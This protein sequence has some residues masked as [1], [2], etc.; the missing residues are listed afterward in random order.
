MLINIACWIR[1][2][3]LRSI[4]FN[5][6][7][8][9]ALAL[10]VF[11]QAAS[12]AAVFG[13]FT[14]EDR[15]LLLSRD[16]ASQL[17]IHTRVVAVDVNG[18]P[19]FRVLSFPQPEQDTREIIR[20]AKQRGYEKTWYF[21][22]ASARSPVAD[23]APAKSSYR[24][25][26]TLTDGLA[27]ATKTQ[28]TAMDSESTSPPIQL[29]IGGQS[30]DVLR[31]DA[32]QINIDGHINEDVWE[33][34]APFDRLTVLNP[35]T[36][37]PGR[38]ETQTRVFY[39]DKGLYVAALM[40]QPAATLVERLSGRDED[41]NRDGFSLMLDT[42]GQ[43][44]YGY[45]FGI[46]LGGTKQDGKLAPESV[47][48]YEWDG[49]W[50]GKTQSLTDGWSAEIF[51]PW[52]IL[53]MPETG[54]QRRLAIFVARKVAYLDE[55]WGWPQLPLSGARF[56]SGFQPYEIQQIPLGQQWE[57]YPYASAT[58]DRMRQENDERVGADLSWR[59]SSNLQLT[60]TL[61]PDFG[62]VESDDV[63][64]NLTAYE[65]YF[66][67]KRLFFLEGTEVF[68]TT[69]RSRS[70][71]SNPRGSGGR[72]AILPYTME[73]TTL[74]NTRRIGGAP[75]NVEIPDGVSVAGVELSKPTELFGAVKAVGQ[76]GNLRYGFLS[77]FENESSFLGQ[78]DTSGAAVKLKNEGRDFG[79]ARLLYEE[80]SGQGRKSIGYLGTLASSEQQDA[81][82]HGIDT[83]WMS[84]SGKWSID[85]QF[86][87][88]EKADAQGYGLFVDL[89]YTPKQGLSHSLGIDALDDTLDIS[90]LGYLRTNDSYGASYSFMAMK[91]QGLP[92]WLRNQTLGVFIRA[93]QNSDGYLNRGYAGVF[94]NLLFADNSEFRMEMNHLPAYYDDKNS[95]GNGLF[96]YEGGHMVLFSYGTSTAKKFST[97]IQF[98]SRGGMDTDISYIADFG[99]TY[100]PVDRFSM[101]FDLGFVQS[102]NWYLHQ[103]DTR[104]TSFDALQIRPG[105]SMDYFISANQQL[106]FSL[107]WIGIVAEENEFWSVPS[108]PGR[109]TRRNKENRSNTDDFSLS[110][111]TSQ[112]RYRWE[113][114]P[115]SDLFVVYT[116]GSNLPNRHNDDFG[117]LF[118][119][120]LDQP[121]IETFTVKLRYRFSS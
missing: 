5:F 38:H 118:G 71:W 117:S 55:F 96:Q 119:N 104:F 28:P 87:T 12:G 106:R 115:L 29:T 82:V 79:V 53:T 51:I 111:M 77:A 93:N 20:I 59:P 108:T 3:V 41:V 62:S 15:A 24:A 60:A 47:M 78:N 114:A 89:G 97:S 74:L 40:K 105:L 69:P 31:L 17:S 19:F 86:M 6:C 33:Q 70:S 26:I 2:R 98:G 42:S 10:P 66:P 99:F 63:V 32:A 14:K 58:T 1:E 101:N 25:P 54:A 35:D 94:A 67:E 72:S 73:P 36:L 88:S 84:S 11:S 102:E 56:I 21:P 120:A 9:L 109:L 49:A 8:I 116:R 113:I 112:L 52:S 68:E 80:T 30:G 92:N 7:T 95:R 43:G 81:V 13:S 57:A 61:N 90:D 75:R 18:T 64:V 100:R 103:G 4:W 34:I 121:I 50:R 22:E 44:L 83:H 85:N 48:S 76:S 27:L 91:S 107:Q 45:I 110:Q 23:A 37:K 16:V 39:D 46:N 65:T